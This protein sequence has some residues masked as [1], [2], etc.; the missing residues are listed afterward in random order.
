MKLLILKD[1][2]AYPSPELKAVPAF[3]ELV[4]RD[5]DRKKIKSTLEFTWLFFMYNPTSPYQMLE[6][7]ERK[8]KVA[9]ILFGDP[10]WKPDEKLEYAAERYKEMVHSLQSELLD[11]ATEAARNL[12]DYLRDTDLTQVDDKGKP[13]HKV[14][15]MIRALKEM[16]PLIESLN[17]LQEQVERQEDKK[18]R[19]VGDL[20]LNKYSE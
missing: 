8:V 1:D 17:K 18:N 9:D 6:E 15:D 4:T 5:K 7:E 3:R 2:Y 11:A 16:G 14:G 20:Q 19:T 10:K 12:T 13:I